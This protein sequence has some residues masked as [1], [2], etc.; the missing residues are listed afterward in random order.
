MP[1]ANLPTKNRPETTNG[2]GLSCIVDGGS[3][4]ATISVARF[5]PATAP[6]I[7]K[8][9][10]GPEDNHAQALLICAGAWSRGRDAWKGPLH[11]IITPSQS[12][13]TPAARTGDARGPRDT[14]PCAPW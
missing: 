9:Y 10:N 14:H 12:M 8:G 7:G 1:D 5:T 2:L 4:N 11:R 6:P 13:T 3:D